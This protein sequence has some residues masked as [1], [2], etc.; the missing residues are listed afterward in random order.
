MDK[1]TYEPIRENLSEPA[2]R[3]DLQILAGEIGERLDALPSREDFSKLLNSVDRLAAQVQTYNTERSA[4]TNRLE[5]LESWAK[6]ASETINVP[7]EF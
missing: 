3:G 7:I 5:R 6:K 4:E 1:T 2:T